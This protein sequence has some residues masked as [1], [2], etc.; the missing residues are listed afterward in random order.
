MLINISRMKKKI[1]IIFFIIF[2]FYL[3]NRY[4]QKIDNFENETILYEDTLYG[5]F[6]CFKL[7]KVICGAIGSTKAWEQHI[8]EELK[9]YYKEGT[10][11]L[12]IGANYGCHTLY[13][14]NHIKNLNK[15]GKVYAFDLQPKILELLKENVA[16]NNLQNYI[17]VLEYGLGEKEES[18]ELIIPNDYDSHENPGGVSLHNNNMNDKSS[19]ISVNIKKLDDLGLNNISLIKIDVEG[20]ELEAL[21]GGKQTIIQ[22]KPVILIE[23]WK[24]NKD[25]YFDWIQKNFPFYNIEHISNDDYRL[26]PKS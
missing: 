11:M 24:H 20:F 22:N 3:F 26:I 9:K 5:K 10:N 1:I 7:D 6:K 23:I 2:I 18:K 4:L 19:K 12:D 13:I 17:D 25:K 16:I 21:E 15:G 8:S 14:G